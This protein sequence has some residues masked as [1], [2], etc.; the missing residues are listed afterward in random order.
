MR[1]AIVAAIAITALYSVDSAAQWPKYPDAS[2]PR[3]A[4][5]PK[6][7]PTSLVAAHRTS[8][9]SLIDWFVI[10]VG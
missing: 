5:Q 8:C 9:A 2:V 3:D 6:P 4:E 7:D 10:S 1:K